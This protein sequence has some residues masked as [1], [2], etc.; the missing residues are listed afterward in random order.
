[1]C[2]KIINNRYGF[3]VFKRYRGELYYVIIERR[4]SYGFEL[5]LHGR[6]DENDPNIITAVSI[7]IF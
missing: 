1:M 7:K 6:Y 3:I 5:I 4:I 2:D